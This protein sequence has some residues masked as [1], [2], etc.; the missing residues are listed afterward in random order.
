MDFESGWDPICVACAREERIAK[1]SKLRP[2]A[3][4]AEIK[5]AYS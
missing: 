1:R 4:V 5:K 3:S 2:L